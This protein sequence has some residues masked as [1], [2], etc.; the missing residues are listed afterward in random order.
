ML[1]R[2]IPE[3]E[4]GGGNA[5]GNV[6]SYGWLVRGNF[7]NYMGRWYLTKSNYMGGWSGSISNSVGIAFAAWKGK[8]EYY[9]PKKREVFLKLAKRMH[10]DPTIS[11]LV[12]S[13]D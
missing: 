3:K 8:K 13:S 11:R 2:A 7:S 12:M 10:I 4:G 6:F 5:A 1:L 9:L